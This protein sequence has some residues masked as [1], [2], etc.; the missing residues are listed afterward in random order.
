MSMRAH[1]LLCCVVVSLTAL[2]GSGLAAGHFDVS[3][4]PEQLAC[5]GEETISV[6]CSI[7]NPSQRD[8]SVILDSPDIILCRKLVVVKTYGWKT[9]KLERITIRPGESRQFA[10]T[11]VLGRDVP[12]LDAGTYRLRIDLCVKTDGVVS[13]PHRFA[14]V[15]VRHPKPEEREGD[16]RPVHTAEAVLIAAREYSEE[17]AGPEPQIVDY[18]TYRIRR[19]KRDWDVSFSYRGPKLFGVRK[20]SVN[21]VTNKPYCRPIE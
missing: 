8:L 19:Y 3:L 20:I 5:V 1:V 16:A 13:Y 15:V 6:A 2:A 11:I 4:N 14:K 18:S 12:P 21:T 7:S 10:V 9:R 17:Y